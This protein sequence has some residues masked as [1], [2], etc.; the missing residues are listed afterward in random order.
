MTTSAR[1]QVVAGQAEAARQQAEAAV[2]RQPGDAGPR[3]DAD[4]RREAERLRLVVEVAE[5]A[6]RRPRAPSARSGSTRD[7][8]SCR[9]RSITRPPSQIGVAGDVV[10]AAAHR[11]GQSL[12]AREAR[13]RR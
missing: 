9:E 8:R 1:D 5:R 10:A 13:R 11:H 2:Q 6:R 3:D 12:L 4:R 7:A